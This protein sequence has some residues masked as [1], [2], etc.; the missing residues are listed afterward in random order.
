MIKRVIS[1][2]VLWSGLVGLIWFFGPQAAVWA[3]ALIGVLA[4]HEFYAILSKRGM[5]P[6]NK[7]GVTLGACMLLGPYYIGT[8]LMDGSQPGRTSVFLAI[9]TGILAA[10]I[11]L[12]CVRILNEREPQHRVEA[13]LA[14]V[15][16][17]VL[18]PFLLQFFVCIF[19]LGRDVES[20]LLLAVWLLAVTKFCDTGALLTGLAIG[21]TKMAPSISPKK[22]W[23]GAAGGV[24][25]A[26]LVGAGLA[27]LLRDALP[28]QFTVM[29]AAAAAI[30][31]AVF[32]IIGDLVESMIK[33]LADVKD[34]GTMVPGIGGAFD[35]IDSV[36]LAAP[37]GYLIFLIAL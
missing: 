36:L 12:C 30:P 18:I 21:R 29:I 33:R 17:L 22:T 19:F 28:E 5:Q 24:L 1:T 34:S 13:L 9:N 23:E 15:F 7:L 3:I 20:G 27:H 11:L 16:G 8:M 26:V 32:G 14:T 35:L 31:V 4:Q 2:V 6:F 10:A 25:V 37:V